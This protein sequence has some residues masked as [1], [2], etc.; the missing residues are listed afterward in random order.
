M[1]QQFFINT[2]E[3]VAQLIN[4]NA[5]TDDY[6]DELISIT[7]KAIL[8]EFF[9]AFWQNVNNSNFEMADKILRNLTTTEHHAFQHPE[10]RM[11]FFKTWITMEISHQSVEQVNYLVS[12]FGEEIRNRNR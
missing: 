10:N 12:K 1:E 2:K 11:G 7:T 9:S 3:S 8:I 5:F 4:T 6:C